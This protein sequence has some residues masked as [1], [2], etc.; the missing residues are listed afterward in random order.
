[1]LRQGDAQVF[2]KYSRMKL[3]MKREAREKLDR[4]ANEMTAGKAGDR[5]GTVNVQ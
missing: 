4:R 5:I 2:E 3:Q 1:M